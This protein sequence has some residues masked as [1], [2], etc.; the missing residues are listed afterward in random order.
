MD[1]TG[2]NRQKLREVFGESA[3]EGLEL[4]YYEQENTLYLHPVFGK[5]WGIGAVAEVLRRKSDKQIGIV[6]PNGYPFN[7]EQ[8]MAL[9]SLGEQYL[10]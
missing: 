2:A 3:D 4:V 10:H 1:I 6:A 5:G 8:A 7:M 9:F